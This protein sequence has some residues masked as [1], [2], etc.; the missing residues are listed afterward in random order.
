MLRTGQSICSS[1]HCHSHYLPILLVALN[2]CHFDEANLADHLGLHQTLNLHEYCYKIT[3]AIN[4][5]IYTYKP[6]HL[7]AHQ[8]GEHMVQETKKMSGRRAHRGGHGAVVGMVAPVAV[9]AVVAVFRT[10]DICRNC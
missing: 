8:L 4:I 6:H 9:L 5:R 7:L 1:T 2:I 3:L 10:D